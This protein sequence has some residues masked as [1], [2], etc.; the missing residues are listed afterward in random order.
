[1]QFSK[2]NL[3]DKM[4]LTGIPLNS[5][6]ELN[7]ELNPQELFTVCTQCQRVLMPKLRTRSC[8]STPSSSIRVSRD[9]ESEDRWINFEDI[10]KSRLINLSHG[11]CS[12]CFKR[13]DAILVDSVH[14]AL[15]VSDNLSSSPSAPSIS[16]LAARKLTKSISS[17]ILRPRNSDPAPTIPAPTN[18]LVVD[19]N[20]LQGKIHKRMVE[21]AGFKCDV[22]EN[23]AQAISMA[24]ETRYRLVL[25]DLVMAGR[26]GWS[27]AR[28]IRK[29]SLSGA[30]TGVAPP[31]IVAVTGLHIDD[32]LIK[33]C[34]DAGMEDIIHKPV[35]PPMMSKLLSS[36]AEKAVE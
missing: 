2:A 11:L 8:P 21:Q 25:M 20:R 36:I 14:E 9:S 30:D 4:H 3:L 23:G 28:R 7:A 5:S 26:D 29:N 10:S 34:A 27:T 6:Q 17:P 1:M 22:A 18:V 35:S 33:D 16:S 15:S 19:D 13:M 31:R 32:K 24:R 12:S